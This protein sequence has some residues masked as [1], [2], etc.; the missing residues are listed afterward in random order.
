MNFKK[1][2]L[3]E[4]IFPNK[5]ATVYHRTCGGCNEY[6]S[7]KAVSG[8]LTNNYKIGDGCWS[9]TNLT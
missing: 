8:I 7:I 3:S 1:W 6:R 9:K 2:I 5:N 4:E